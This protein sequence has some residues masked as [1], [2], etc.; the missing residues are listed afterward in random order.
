MSRTMT[1]AEAKLMQ[2]LINQTRTTPRVAMQQMK[3]AQWFRLKQRTFKTNKRSQLMKLTN[4]YLYA[5]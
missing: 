3:T 4:D 5:S 2:S 1:S